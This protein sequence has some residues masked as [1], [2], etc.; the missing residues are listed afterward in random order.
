MR[1]VYRGGAVLRADTKTATREELLS[2]RMSL[3]PRVTSKAGSRESVRDFIDGI[4]NGRWRNEVEPLRQIYK[5]AGRDAYKAQ[6]LA[7][8]EVVTV[9]GV[10]SR[11]NND[12][13]ESH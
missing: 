2:R 10:F 5:E 12:G 7:S 11:R 1:V 6:R 13:L 3:Y 8:L 4:K 9:S